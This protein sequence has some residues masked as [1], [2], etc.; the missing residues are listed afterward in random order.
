MEVNSLTIPE[1]REKIAS[2]SLSSREVVDQLAQRI[3][4]VDPKIKA[5]LHLDLEKA[6]VQA[7]AASTTL[8]LGGVPMANSSMFVRPMS[9]APASRSLVMTVAS[10]G[11]T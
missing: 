10:K 11:A 4:T 7:D 8:P 1:L 3:E 5:Y 2:G 6:R 9:T